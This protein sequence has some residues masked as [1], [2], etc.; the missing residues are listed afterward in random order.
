M[1]TISDIFRPKAIYP[2]Y[3]PYHVG[4]YQEEYFYK[5]WN[6]NPQSKTREY[7]DVFWTNLYCNSSYMGIPIPNIQQELHKK[8]DWNGRYFTVCQHDDGPFENLPPDTTIFISGGNRK[9]GNIVALPSI[10]SKLPIKYIE[11]DDRK[12]LA[13]FIGS[14]THPIR[15]Q[16]IEACKNNPNIKIQIKPWTP[17]VSM[18]DLNI[19]V[20]LSYNSKFTLAP[21]GYGRSSFRMYEAMQL[22]SIPVYIADDHFLPWNDELNYDEFCVIMT[23]KDL[24]YIN[25]I[26]QS[27]DDYKIKTMRFKMQEVWKSHFSLDGMFDQ[28]MRRLT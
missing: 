19:F 17:N 22:G 3:P 7:I 13:S 4:E 11:N 26:L 28:I 8:L 27:Y 21:R 5:R 20:N 15:R 25:E 24:P 9:Y 2:T 1:K 10:C 14:D 23:S 16:M 12:L 6:E 18:N